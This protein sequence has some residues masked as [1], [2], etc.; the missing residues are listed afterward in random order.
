[1]SRHRGAGSFRGK[2]QGE[3]PG[4]SFISCY[5]V[6]PLSLKPFIHHSPSH[7]EIW[8][9]PSMGFHFADRKTEAAKVSQLAIGRAGIPT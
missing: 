5:R 9:S 2:I 8:D 7:L 4:P 6:L 1:M 3:S